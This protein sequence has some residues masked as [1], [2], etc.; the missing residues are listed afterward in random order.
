MKQYEKSD[1]ATEMG[2]HL[3]IG[4]RQKIFF[5]AAMLL[6]LLWVIPF[7]AMAQTWQIGDSKTNTAAAVTAILSGNTLTISGSGNMADFDVSAGG[8]PWNNYLTQIKT[9]VINNT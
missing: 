1:K 5:K 4:A 2:K 6:Y 7:M 9:V 3:K 8:I